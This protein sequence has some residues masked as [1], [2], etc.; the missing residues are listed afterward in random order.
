VICIENKLHHA[1]QQCLKKAIRS[2]WQEI[3]KSSL[4]KW[5][6]GQLIVRVIAKTSKDTSNIREEKL[7]NHIND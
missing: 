1:V 6:Q 2:C 3:I 5:M 7:I 4:E